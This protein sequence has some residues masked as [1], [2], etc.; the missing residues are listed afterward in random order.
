MNLFTVETQVQALEKLKNAFCNRKPSSELVHLSKAIGRTLSNDLYASENIPYFR[1]SMVDGY[2]VCSKNTHGASDSAPILLKLQGEVLMGSLAKLQL[3]PQSLIYVPT[4]GEVPEGADA[5]VMIEYTEPFGDE[6]AIMT[7]AAV[8]EHIVGIGED[9]SIGSL[10][11]KKGSKIE[12]RHIGLLASL[13][14]SEVEVLM[15]SLK[16]AIFSTGDELIDL[17]A[18]MEPGKIRDCNRYIISALV[19]SL[20]CEVVKVERVKDEAVS[21][22]MAIEKTLDLADVIIL[23]GGS[24]VGVMDYTSEVI[25]SLG[26]PGVLTHGLAI[27]P[28]KPTISAKVSQ[29]AIFGLPGHPSACFT[30]FIALVAPFIHYL[31]G[32]EQPVFLEVPCTSN[33]QLHAAS[34]RDAYQ[35]VK[36]RKVENGLVA[37]AV[38]GKSGM[39]SQMSLADAFVMIPMSTEGVK[40][41]DSL[42][43]NMLK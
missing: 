19:E 5:M 18:P 25:Q 16:V 2:G 33:F 43:A 35:M 28:G 12:A 36:L 8:N 23:S 24:S 10:I 3:E 13:G 20:G 22:K 6:I 30:A 21:L 42:W 11:L 37:D 34:G 39:V 17:E 27:K 14:I 1:R 15:T 4:G 9:V 38:L 29:T 26:E 41:G 31:Q 7:T 32:S 40:V